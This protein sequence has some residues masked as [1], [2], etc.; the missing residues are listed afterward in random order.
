MRRAVLALLLLASFVLGL[1]AGAHPCQAAHGAEQAQAEQASQLPSCHAGMAQR[2]HDAHGAKTP[3]VRKGAPSQSER[4]CCEIACQHAC[5]LV[6]VVSFQP[7]TLPA[8]LVAQRLVAT[9]ERGS[10][11]FAGGIDHIPLL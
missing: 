6:A 4:N 7:V 1:T 3:S 11:P 10:S 2:S 8:V 9:V 5:H